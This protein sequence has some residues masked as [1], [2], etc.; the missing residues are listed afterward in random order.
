[1]IKKI[2]LSSSVTPQALSPFGTSAGPN[3]YAYVKNNLLV[4]FDLFGLEDQVSDNHGFFEGV[5]DFVC[6]FFHGS[7][8]TESTPGPSQETDINESERNAFAGGIHGGGQIGLECAKGTM[9]LYTA[10]IYVALK[11][12]S[13]ATVEDLIADLERYGEISDKIDSLADG[14][15][16]VI[17]P[18]NT[19]SQEYREARLLTV[20]VG[21]AI[22]IVR[23]IGQGIAGGACARAKMVEKPGS[24]WSSTRDKSSI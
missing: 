17:L 1:M 2:V 4:L 12:H 19:D 16:Q 8:D 20:R 23:G 18:A 15:M 3:L 14:A 5:W 10:A 9:S 24:I 13:E 7:Q 6:D 11:D 22:N 21:W